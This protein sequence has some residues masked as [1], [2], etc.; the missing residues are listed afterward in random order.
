MGMY[1]LQSVFSHGQLYVALSR[2]GIK[3]QAIIC[4][5]ENGHNDDGTY[6]RSIVYQDFSEEETAAKRFRMSCCLS[7]LLVTGWT[8]WHMSS[9]PS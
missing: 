8:W 7:R 5:V 6:A 1:L 4:V 9:L 3:E 2:V